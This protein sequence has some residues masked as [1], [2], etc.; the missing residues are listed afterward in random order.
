MFVEDLILASEVGLQA[1]YP[2]LK[3]FEIVEGGHFGAFE[4]PKE[5]VKYAVKF[6]G[7]VELGKIK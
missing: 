2:H 1:K 4:V 3:Q 7:G 6:F 5:V